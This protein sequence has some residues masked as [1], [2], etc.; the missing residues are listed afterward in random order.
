[1][2][3]IIKIALICGFILTLSPWVVSAVSMVYLILRYGLSPVDFRLTSTENGIALFISSVG[4][5][6]F[7]AAGTIYAIMQFWQGQRI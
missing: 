7:I 1:M 5:I 2:L 6:V 3:K 4:V